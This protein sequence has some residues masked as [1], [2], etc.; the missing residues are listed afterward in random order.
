MRRQ[1]RRG[2]H[3]SAQSP[4][5]ALSAPV[6]V[7]AA[8][9]VSASAGGWFH[10]HLAY[11]PHLAAAATKMTT[12]T[13]MIIVTANGAT[14]IIIIIHLLLPFSLQFLDQRCRPRE[15]HLQLYRQ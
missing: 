1:R 4:M 11:L 7:Q 5:R 15:Q 13:I 14:L 10:P 3:P 12:A 9:G 2:A 8:S 6:T